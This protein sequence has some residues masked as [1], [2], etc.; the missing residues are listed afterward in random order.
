MVTGI[1][2]TED[3]GNYDYTP[4]NKL[5]VNGIKET[6]VVE[7]DSMLS[8]PVDISGSEGFREDDY[9]YVWYAWRTSVEKVPDTLSVKKDLNVKLL[10]DVGEYIL[11]YVITEKASGVFFESKIN[12][13]VINKY[14]KGVMALS[15]IEGD[16]S[17]VTFINI[18]KYGY[19]TC[20]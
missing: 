19:P 2:C 18:K 5:V 1:A 12:L 3:K 16:D 6:Y 11:R 15:R 10:L 14:S 8:I 7:V 17:D 4:L 20:L 13:N 9:D